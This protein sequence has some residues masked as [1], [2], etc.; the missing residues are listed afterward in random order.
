MATAYEAYTGEQFNDT[1]LTTDFKD[2]Q[3]YYLPVSLSSTYEAQQEYENRYNLKDVG[4]NL[5]TINFK[6]RFEFDNYLFGTAKDDA[7]IVEQQE[8]RNKDSFTNTDFKT[9]KITPSKAE[10]VKT[11][12]E[13][14]STNYL[15][16]FRFT[17]SQF[18]ESINNAIR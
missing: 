15:H 1:I 14:R 13:G 5:I 18:T 17:D 12:Q 16:D 4:L 8:T 9:I 10:Q 7:V 6:Q 2:T 3:Y 11:L